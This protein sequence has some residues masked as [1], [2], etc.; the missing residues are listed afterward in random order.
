ML[1]HGSVPFVFLCWFEFRFCLPS[2][3]SEV[4]ASQSVLRTSGKCR[5]D[6]G[7]EYHTR[8]AKQ[9]LTTL[10]AAQPATKEPRISHTISASAWHVYL[11]NTF[12]ALHQVR[13][14]EEE[15]SSQVAANNR[16]VRIEGLGLCQIV[17]FFRCDVF[18]AFRA[19]SAGPQMERKKGSKT[20]AANNKQEGGARGPTS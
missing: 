9:S 5:Q 7:P 4:G 11:A 2:R 1:S 14:G 19:R 6:S 3:I 13:H 18:R 8:G 12:T 20:L 15:D 17:V 10:E 16:L